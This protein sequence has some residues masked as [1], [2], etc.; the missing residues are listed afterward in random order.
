MYI[1]LSHR[2]LIFK[3]LK[4]LTL[5]FNEGNGKTLVHTDQTCSLNSYIS[6]II[7]ITLIF[8]KKKTEQKKKES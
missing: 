8:L 5:A 1:L 7:A 2:I 6:S 3:R 4:N